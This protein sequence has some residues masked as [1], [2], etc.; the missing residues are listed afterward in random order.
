MPINTPLPQQEAPFSSLGPQIYLSLKPQ[1]LLCAASKPWNSPMPLGFPLQQSHSSSTHRTETSCIKHKLVRLLSVILHLYESNIN[2][3]AAKPQSI[4]LGLT[5]DVKIRVLNRSLLSLMKTELSD[6]Q[7]AALQMLTEL[8]HLPNTD[9]HQ[10]H[11]FRSMLQLS[12][13][14]SCS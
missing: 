11:R 9:T 7:T 13:K 3:K 1:L 12:G 2:N 14:A 8:F 5:D 10:R 4:I 6:G